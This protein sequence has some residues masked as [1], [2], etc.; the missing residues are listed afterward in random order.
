MKFSLFRNDKTTN[1]DEFILLG[2]IAAFLAAGIALLVLRPSFWIIG[3]SFSLGLGVILTI[4]GIMFIPGLIY[5]F[6]NN[7]KQ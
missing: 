6:M 7:D 5:R 2:I 4:T 3:Q 1:K